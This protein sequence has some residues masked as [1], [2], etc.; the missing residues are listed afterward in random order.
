LEILE[1][2]GQGGM[3]AVYKTRQRSL[4]RLVALKVIPAAAGDDPTFVERFHREARTLAKL[5]HPN[6]V[7]AYDYGQVNGFC[8][9]VMEYIAG[10]NLREVLR[11]GRLA[12]CEALGIAQQVC[13]ALCYAHSLGVVHRDIKP[14]NILLEELPPVVPR[15]GDPAGSGRR[16]KIT[17]F[18]LAK[19]LEAE[20]S[21]FALT[22][23]EHVMGTPQYMAPEQV[24]RPQEVD[25]RADLYA[26]GVVLYEML[27]GELPLGNFQPVSSKA[28]VGGRVDELVLRLLEKE[29]ERRYQRAA[30]LRD[31]LGRIAASPGPSRRRRKL[32][33]PAALALTCLLVA[34]LAF[35]AWPTPIDNR[36][37]QDAASADKA[38]GAG[39]AEAEA[40]RRGQTSAKAPGTNRTS[41]GPGE[42]SVSARPGTGQRE[43]AGQLEAQLLNPKLM[44][45]FPHQSLRIEYRFH[46]ERPSPGRR[47]FWVI[48]SD[49]GWV[50]EQSLLWI[51]LGAEGTLRARF[52]PHGIDRGPYETY[53]E[54][55][56]YGPGR[57]RRRISNIVRIEPLPQ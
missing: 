4:D 50:G 42:M 15:E 10:P 26:L 33:R 55:E 18:G 49:R 57:S 11:A 56:Q 53:L 34:A 25:H 38:E 46:Q 45:D 28:D 24:E 1:L 7:A 20:P 14:E 31:E 9:I 51:D 16:V 43:P 27:S 39:Q 8:Y 37:Q 6:L 30:E 44:D 40:S 29:P 36:G 12:P 35:L 19:L 3:G 22:T 5:S 13:D 17:D 47:Y 52:W 32:P 48:E 23:S 54:V 41:D 2:L 21:G